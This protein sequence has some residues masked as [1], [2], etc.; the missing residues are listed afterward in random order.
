MF[1]VAE[2]HPDSA[3]DEGNRVGF[4][5]TAILTAKDN[6]VKVT[7][8]DGFEIEFTINKDVP[9]SGRVDIELWDVG[10]MPI[11]VGANEGQYID[12]AIPKCQPQ[13]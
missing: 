10:T 11:Q 8:S 4:K 13:H 12:I 7:D 9:Y 3:D 2:E 1:E 5:D 6:K